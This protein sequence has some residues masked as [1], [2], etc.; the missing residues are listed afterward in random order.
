MHSLCSKI[1]LSVKGGFPEIARNL[2]KPEKTGIWVW[3]FW[4]WAD[5]NP[6]HIHENIIR[7]NNLCNAMGVLVCN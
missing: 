5:P 3:R 2:E 1:V 7:Q 4:V 6:L